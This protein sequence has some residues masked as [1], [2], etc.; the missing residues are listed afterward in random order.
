MPDGQLYTRDVVDARPTIE[1]DGQPIDDL[2]ENL[3]HFE[4]REQ[5]GGLTTV[6]ILLSNLQDS[7]G[8]AREFTF[9]TERGNRFYP[10]AAINVSGGDRSG[11]RPLF[12]G[13]VSAV[14]FE[15][16]E[17]NRPRLRVLAE[18]ALMAWR[19][20]RRNRSF[21]P[22]TVRSVFEAL[23]QGTGL[24]PVITGLAQDV[25][26]Q[27]QVNETDL[28][29]L[30]RLL[31]R[32]DADAQV[33]G[34][35]LH[36]SP[37][38]EVDRGVVTLALGEDLKSCRI[39]ADLADQRSETQIHGFSVVD[40]VGE[41]ITSQAGDLGPGDGQSGTELVEDAF[42]VAVDLLRMTAFGTGSEAQTIANAMQ[43]ARTRRFVTAEGCTVGN[44]NLRVGTHVTLQE[45][46]P[47]FSNTYTCVRAVH[48]Y[49]ERA[50]Y[51]TDFTAETA[52]L[53]RL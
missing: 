45:A 10:G 43:T 47:R 25:D 51:I 19:M 42:P 33:V 8:G 18:D 44:V 39:V 28:G 53:G 34:E 2:D 27:Q 32:Y 16:G 3:I 38:S 52:Y 30:R 15:S 13:V 35:E 36:I 1:V 4:L 21:E 7:E 31:V 37:R 24:S 6:E 50:G 48:R 11:P 22:G 17:D 5:V 23:T 26:S 46:G 20:V 9:E 41:E 14:A 49:T 40:G 12:Q 29:F